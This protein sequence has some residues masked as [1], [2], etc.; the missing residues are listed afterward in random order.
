MKP[1]QP[2]P[3]SARNLTS[4][5]SSSAGKKLTD[6]AEEHHLDTRQR[7]EMAAKI[8]EA[9]H[10]A[11]QRGL[12]HRDLKP[13][14]ILV[15]ET[16]QPKIVDFG[17]ARTTDSDMQ[18]T[19][20]TDM[21]QLVGTLA[22]MSPEQVLADPLEL[23]I[24]SDVYA[25][26][27][28]LYELLAGRL[29]YTIGRRLHENLQAIR[30]NDP[31]KLSALNR[32]YRGDIETIVGKAL[33]KDKTLRYASAAGLAEDLHRY[34]K[35]EPIAARP[36]ST[37]YQLRKFTRRHKALVT[38]VTAVFIVLVG[39]LIAFASM[40]NL[41]QGERDHANN[42]AA[43]KDAVL[44]FM[45]IVVGQ[46]NPDTQG[47]SGQPNQPP[48][49]TEPDPTLLSAFDSAVQQIPILFDGDLL[50]E[51]TVREFAGD[52][53]TGMGR[54]SDAKDQLESAMVRRRLEQGNTHPDTIRATSKLAAVYSSLKNYSKASDLATQ[55]VL[56]AR[57]TTGNV[58][59]DLR[60]AVSTLVFVYSGTL[61]NPDQA[62]EFPKIERFLKDDFLAYQRSESGEGSPIVIFAVA[63]LLS[64]Y[65]DSNP[66]KY[67][68][69]A[70]FMS[71]IADDRRRALGEDHPA[72]LNAEKQVI[73]LYL[74]ESKFAEAEA[75]LN[76]LVEAQ[77]R[78]LG[79]HYP[80]TMATINYLASVY[81]NQP[82]PRYVEAET[83]L[84]RVKESANYDLGSESS[85]VQ[86]ATIG[87]AKLY[88]K[89]ARYAEAED[90]LSP[91]ASDAA[92]KKAMENEVAIE[93]QPVTL[94]NLD[95][96]QIYGKRLNTALDRWMEQLTMIERPTILDVLDLLDQTYLKRGNPVG[97]NVISSK[98]RA[99]LAA[100]FNAERNTGPVDKNSVT[101]M[102][103]M[104]AIAMRYIDQ[105]RY[106]KQ[107]TC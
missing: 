97:A 1:A 51:A 85:A 103:S 52:T 60:R 81:L 17:V 3:A 62:R 98:L 8:A 16:G 11:H 58:D 2:I 61:E 37:T 72:T 25:L 7:M 47:D 49:Q 65:T 107:N 35:D 27:V 105:G 48:Y 79:G 6:Y 92:V 86:N 43:G 82:H 10:H 63:Q 73:G 12:I 31:L 50:L 89:Q 76:T 9:V 75:Y 56:N 5:W 90:L 66:P 57:S 29:P 26:G 99:I 104:G 20:Q 40:A 87:L 32:A 28:I 67:I 46:A 38:G 33:E 19:S 96:S 101:A 95:R 77:W 69:A 22:Y 100:K 91:L 74:M 102:R 93:I 24:R 80:A 70:M 34:L 53:Y 15:D 44:E 36:P 23:D 42:E 54:Y 64:L 83:F 4:R 68:E 106:P 84:K 30:E 14:N 21:G 59:E 94:D 13:A 55:V 78:T 41:Y 18:A 39:G 45:R 88:F 71:Q